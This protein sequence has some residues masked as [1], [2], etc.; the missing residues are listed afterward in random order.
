MAFSQSSHDESSI[1]YSALSLTDALI[2]NGF[3]L[4]DLTAVAHARF[5][6]YEQEHFY[7]N[8][9]ESHEPEIDSDCPF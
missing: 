2:L 8:Q 4:D 7:E 3:S 9:I 1:D 5:D 6:E